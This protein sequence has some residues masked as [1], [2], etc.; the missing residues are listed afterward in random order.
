MSD[1]ISDALRHLIWERAAYTCEYCL[2]KATDVLLPHQVDHIIAKQHGGKTDA[3]NLALA[4][5]HCNRH[6][7]SNIASMDPE[8]TQL[9]PL[10]NPRSQNWSE[11]FALEGPYIQPLTSIGRVTI[12][13]LKLNHSERIRVRLALLEAGVYP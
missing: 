11:H 8:T 2:V 7:G 4:C 9:T 5:I 1:H 3:S 10:Y 13:L 12:G 6:K